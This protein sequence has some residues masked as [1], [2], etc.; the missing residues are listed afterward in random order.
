MPGVG[1]TA[2][3]CVL[4]AFAHRPQVVL[5]TNSGKPLLRGAEP[6]A[7]SS[8][9]VED[10][11]PAAVVAAAN[12]PN[13]LPTAE[14]PVAAGGDGSAAAAG[15]AEGQAGQQQE[16]LPR[17]WSSPEEMETMARFGARLCAHSAN[18]SSLVMCR[19]SVVAWQ[20]APDP[21]QTQTYVP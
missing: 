9:D 14:P 7:S 16:A 12:S 4:P 10:A 11:G 13:V 6:S 18:G 1:A 17:P 21:S 15:Q 2:H 8:L 3:L 19:Q 20:L 5:V